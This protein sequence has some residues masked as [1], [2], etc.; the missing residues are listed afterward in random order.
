M[1]LMMAQMGMSGLSTFASY[2]DARGEAR[3]N[4]KMQAYRN[5][6]AK[7][8][9]ARQLNA[10]TQNEE[11]IKGQAAETDSLIQQQNIVQKGRAAVAAAAAGVAGNSV[12]V[13][14]N[15]LQASA[16]KVSYAQRRQA[17]QQLAELGETRKTIAIN[18]ILGEDIQVIPKPSVGALLLGV[19]TNMLSIYD[20]HQ[21]EGSK[22]I[23]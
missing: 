8:G 7:L 19:G 23:R 22:L 5:T 18:T 11:L 3:I 10:V 9:A 14:A 2:M 20:S 6:I 16:N 1:N 15:D 17:N 4:K 13:V 21:P 12:D